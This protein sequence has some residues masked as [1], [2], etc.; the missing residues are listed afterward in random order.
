M[1]RR[2]ARIVAAAAGLAIVACTGGVASATTRYNECRAGGDILTGWTEYN[3]STQ[4]TWYVEK[5]GFNLE[6]NNG[7]HNNV[8]LRLRGKEG[9]VTYWP[10]TSKDDIVGGKSYTVKVDKRVPRADKPYM[11]YHA[12]F[13]QAGGDPSCDAYTNL[14]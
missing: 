11:K 13:D 3:I 8:Y 2:L 9:D 4:N 12:T 14:T 10:W 6:R 5:A 1:N 7:T